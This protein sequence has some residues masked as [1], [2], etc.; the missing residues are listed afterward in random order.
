M[1]LGLSFNVN[2]GR[3]KVARELTIEEI[4]NEYIAWL[5]EKTAEEHRQQMIDYG[6]LVPVDPMSKGT[7]SWLGPNH[8]EFV[9]DKAHY[10]VNEDDIKFFGGHRLC[11]SNIMLDVRNG[12]VAI[13]LILVDYAEEEEKS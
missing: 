1:V 3:L 5:N 11:W 2:T 10:V 8:F 4:Q 13:D 9:F 6:E 12:H 7:Y